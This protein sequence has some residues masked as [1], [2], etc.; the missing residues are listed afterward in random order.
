MSTQTDFINL[1]KT[2]AQAGQKQYG[3]LASLTIAQAILES[4]WG[5]RATRS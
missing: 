4:G 5:Q 1:V 2:G 3:V